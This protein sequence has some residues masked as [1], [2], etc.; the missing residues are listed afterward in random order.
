MVADANLDATVASSLM[1]PACRDK[2]AVVFASGESSSS[3]GYRVFAR[4]SGRWRQIPNAA[5]GPAHNAIDA[6][7]LSAN[8]VDVPS[9]K[10]AY[11][12]CIESDTA[13]VLVFASCKSK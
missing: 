13:G 12:D 2:F 11:A 1:E 5:T 6:V 7:V 8:G 4:D 3:L 9:F 10:V